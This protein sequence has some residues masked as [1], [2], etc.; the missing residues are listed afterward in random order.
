M[1]MC[2]LLCILHTE[3]SWHTPLLLLVYDKG[4]RPSQIENTDFY[5]SK[6]RVRIYQVYPSR[7]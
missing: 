5:H 2:K 3:G 1:G 7:K 4:W 6:L